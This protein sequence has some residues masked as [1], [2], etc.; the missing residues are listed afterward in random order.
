M[1][2]QYTYQT[3]IDGFIFLY[4]DHEVR[5]IFNIHDDALN[6]DIAAQGINLD[7]KSLKQQQRI[8]LQALV[9]RY[10]IESEEN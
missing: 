10:E 2:T 3:G 6:R 1:N 8:V 9:D 4:Q 7:K 5:S